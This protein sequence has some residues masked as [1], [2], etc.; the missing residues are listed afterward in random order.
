MSAE[1]V[2]RF[3]QTGSIITSLNAVNGSLYFTVYNPNNTS[4]AKQGKVDASGNVLVI[5]TQGHARP[6]SWFE[7]NGVSWEADEW[8]GLLKNTQ[9][10]IE[11]IGCGSRRPC[12]EPRQRPPSK[13]RAC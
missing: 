13:A 1:T 11:K 7:S 4:D 10:N 3:F 8:S 6:I 5:A 2:T 12:V 9:G